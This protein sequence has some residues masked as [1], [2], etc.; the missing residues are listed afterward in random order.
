MNIKRSRKKLIIVGLVV[1]AATILFFSYPSA[2]DPRCILLFCEIG[3]KSC[4]CCLQE[5]LG[6]LECT[7][8]GAFDCPKQI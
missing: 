5:N 2:A 7:P 4:I 3:G 1:I 6:G 8:C